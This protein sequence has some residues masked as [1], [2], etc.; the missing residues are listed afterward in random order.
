MNPGMQIDELILKSGFILLPPHAIDSRR[1]ITLKRVEAVPEK[2]NVEVVEQGSE[3]FLSPFLCCLS[4]TIQPL[5]YAA[6]ALCRV[7]A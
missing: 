4:H 3:P 1:S 7:H 5:G 2:I 6:P